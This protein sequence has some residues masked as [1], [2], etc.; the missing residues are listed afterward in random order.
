M[1][2]RALSKAS[3]SGVRPLLF[4]SCGS[5]PNRHKIVRAFSE[6]AATFTGDQ[7]HHHNDAAAGDGDD[8]NGGSSRS[9]DAV[10]KVRGSCWAEKPTA[11]TGVG[12]I[13]VWRGTTNNLDDFGARLQR[14]RR[15]WLFTL[16]RFMARPR[17]FELRRAAEV[18]AFTP[19]KFRQE[20]E[21]FWELLDPILDGI[22]KTTAVRGMIS[23][24]CS[25]TIL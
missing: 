23:M 15:R 1:R 11:S 22:E 2:S 6:S 3:G 17:E 7:N 25:D 12:I 5:A 10:A 19:Q 4:L 20:W 13:G 9:N 14:R 16:A 24:D 18:R 8:V 21:L